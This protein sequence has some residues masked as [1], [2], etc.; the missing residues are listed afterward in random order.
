MGTERDSLISEARARIIW[1]DSTS[2]VRY[3][4][5]SNGLSAL[6]ADEQI[7]QLALERN[8]EVRK[9]SSRSIVLGVALMLPGAFALYFVFGGSHVHGSLLRTARGIGFSLAFAGYG[10]W[11]VV[12]GIAGLIR[13][14][15][16][17]GSITD[18]Q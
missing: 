3:F 9:S 7:R 16:E 8:R 10:L 15:S 1:G 18:V 2:G 6:E 13:P 14:Q 17:H 5:T 11:K 4:L 12:N